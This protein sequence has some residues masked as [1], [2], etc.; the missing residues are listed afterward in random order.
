MAG[1][2]GSDS[3][4]ALN[5]LM[6]PHTHSLNRSFKTVLLGCIMLSGVRDLL[7]CS[8]LAADINFINAC[9]VKYAV[10]Q[11]GTRHMSYTWLRSEMFTTILD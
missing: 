11:T 8:T 5:D 1:F 7:N 9:H 2:G 6:V 3:L 10:W 4:F